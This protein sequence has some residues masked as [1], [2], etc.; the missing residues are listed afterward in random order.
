VIAFDVYFRELANNVNY[1]FTF[2]IPITCQSP[3]K[4]ALHYIRWVSRR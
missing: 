3:S 4:C 2:L 1:L